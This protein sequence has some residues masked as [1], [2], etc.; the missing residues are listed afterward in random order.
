MD[1]AE[2]RERR[3]LSNPSFL[4][5]LYRRQRCRGREDARWVVLEADEDSDVRGSHSSPANYVATRLVRDELSCIYVLL[6][7][8]VLQDCPT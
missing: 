5:V 8:L 3:G 1:A 2:E 6:V 4:V 7:R